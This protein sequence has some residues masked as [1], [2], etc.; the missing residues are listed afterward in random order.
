MSDD[1]VLNVVS[2]RCNSGIGYTPFCDCVVAIASCGG[3]RFARLGLEEVAAPYAPLSQQVEESDL[4][5]AQSRFKSGT[6]HH[7]RVD[8]RFTHLFVQHNRKAPP[9][10]PCRIK[11]RPED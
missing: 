9:S 1:E 7:H 4:K 6:A 2:I 10:R 3:R 11:T 5:S 8:L